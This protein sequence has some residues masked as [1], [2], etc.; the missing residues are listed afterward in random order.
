LLEL[1]RRDEASEDDWLQAEQQTQGRGRLGRVWDS[2]SGNLHASTIVELR[3]DDPPAQTLSFVA[4]WALWSALGVGSA[5]LRWPNDIVVGSRKLAGILLERNGQIVVV[6]FGANVAHAPSLPDRPTT[7]VSEWADT[8]EV[9]DIFAELRV[10]FRETLAKWRTEGFEWIR[11]RWESEGHM[12]GERLS[13]TLANGMTVTGTYGGLA[14]D[15]GLE[16][17]LAS[18]EVEVIHAGDVS[19]IEDR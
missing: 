16:L 14:A 12:R 15:G 6:G 1:A 2:P 13:V 11:R 17:V 5:S 18:G 8:I 4:G 9:A 10:S 3:E 7:C 19:L